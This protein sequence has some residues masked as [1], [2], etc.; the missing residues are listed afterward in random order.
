MG[1]DLEGSP[2]DIQMTNKHMK[3]CS[4]AYTKELHT[5]TTMRF[6]SAHL[7]KWLKSK[8][9]TNTGEDVKQQELTLVGMQKPLGRVWQFLT[10][11]NACHMMWQPHSLVFTQMS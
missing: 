4:T 1:K 10:E 2:P 9:L 8:T 5:K 6:T 3:R 7:L 11:L